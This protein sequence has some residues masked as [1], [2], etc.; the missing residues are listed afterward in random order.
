MTADRKRRISLILILILTVF[1][2]YNSYMHGVQLVH[3]HAPE[4]SP[5]GSDFVVASIPE[6]ILIAC[7]LRGADWR[8]VSVGSLSVIW[9]LWVNLAAAER[10]PA[11]V[12]VALVPPLAALLLLLLADHD[13]T[14][15]KPVKRR[16]AQTRVK[17]TV[18]PDQNEGSGSGIN[19]GS[20]RGQKPITAA[21]NGSGS[22]G[23]TASTGG[24]KQAR[25]IAWV[26]D[27]AELPSI[28]EIMAAVDVSEATAKRI[29][30]AVT[31]KTGSGENAESSGN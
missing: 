22:K 1:A 24:S 23:V 25:G 14:E 5:F 20:N 3:N 9:T 7:I 13:M 6:V 21:A 18:L 30:R 17:L 10:S 28:K 8:S 4:G 29:R 11:G 27:Q 2:F 16:P 31:G 12:I 19:G 26:T 15:L